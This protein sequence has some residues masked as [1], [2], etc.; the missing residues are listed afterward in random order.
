[1][2]ELVFTHATCLLLLIREENICVKAD[3]DERIERRVS[4]L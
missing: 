2:T 1:M 3:H 4:K